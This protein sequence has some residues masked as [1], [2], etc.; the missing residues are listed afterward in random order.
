MFNMFATLV[1]NCE[2]MSGRLTD[3]LA[4]IIDTISYTETLSQENVD[5]FLQYYGGRDSCHQFK[6][7]FFDISDYDKNDSLYLDSEDGARNQY[8]VLFSLQPAAEQSEL[9]QQDEYLNYQ[10]NKVIKMSCILKD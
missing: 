3:H 2:E 4:N 1:I 9:C 8:L 10:N 7:D 6:N 5:K